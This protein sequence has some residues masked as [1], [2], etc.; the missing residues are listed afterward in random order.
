M[1]LDQRSQTALKLPYLA[2]NDAEFKELDEA[3]QAFALPEAHAQDWADTRFGKRLQRIRNEYESLHAALNEE[4][5]WLDAQIDVN[6]ELLKSGTRLYG[7][8]LNSEKDTAQEAK[9]WNQQYERQ[10]NARPL[11]PREDNVP[12]VSLILY[13]DLGRFEPVKTAQK[14]WRISKDDLTNISALIQKKLKTG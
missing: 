10:M 5:S 8:L 14:D 4:K 1:R 13:E 3:V 6:R 2:K 9:T 7:K 12:G 11:T